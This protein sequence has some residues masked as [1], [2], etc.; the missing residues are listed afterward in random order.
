MDRIVVRVAEAQ[1]LKLLKLLKESM[2]L[3]GKIL[4]VWRRVC[5]R[6]HTFV[7]P[8]QYRLCVPRTCLDTCLRRRLEKKFASWSVAC[9]LA[10]VYALTSCLDDL[11]YQYCIIYPCPCSFKNHENYGS[12]SSHRN[13]IHGLALVPS[14]GSVKCLYSVARWMWHQ[15]QVQMPK[16]QSV[17]R[18]EKIGVSCCS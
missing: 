6:A 18:A 17:Q 16:N 12:H 7:G 1:C 3:V 15:Q 4:K 14:S 13:G 2:V 9:N 8:K 5:A 10:L 11:F